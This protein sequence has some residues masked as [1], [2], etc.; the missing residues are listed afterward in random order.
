MKWLSCC[1]L[2]CFTSC[3]V[4]EYCFFIYNVISFIFRSELQRLCNDFNLNYRDCK[5]YIKYDSQGRIPYNEIVRLIRDSHPFH[6]GVQSPSNV[7]SH[8]YSP[9]YPS[10]TNDSFTPDYPPEDE[11]LGHPR[12]PHVSFVQLVV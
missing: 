3:S 6:N 1:L 11:Y 4:L 5:D 7:H 8:D 10:Y 9:I 12:D 2:F